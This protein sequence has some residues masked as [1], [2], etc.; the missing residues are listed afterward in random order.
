MTFQLMRERNSGVHET[1]REVEVQLSTSTYSPEGNWRGF[2]G[3]NTHQGN[4]ATRDK[5]YGSTSR[6]GE[7]D[8][9]PNPHMVVIQPTPPLPS[10]E[11]KTIENFM[12]DREL[13]SNS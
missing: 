8:E 1:V 7:V 6:E 5:E 11:P 13:V 12:R 2:R 3:N 9:G 10:E 4:E